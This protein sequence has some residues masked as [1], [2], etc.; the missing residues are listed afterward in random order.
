[1]N[2]D[3]LDQ[4]EGQLKVDKNAA[5]RRVIERTLA[6]IKKRRDSSFFVIGIDLTGRPLQLHGLGELLPATPTDRF[7][8]ASSFR[9]AASGGLSVPQKGHSKSRS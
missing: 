8:G 2:T 5:C 3:F 1:M 7:V 9:Q 4:L 6:M